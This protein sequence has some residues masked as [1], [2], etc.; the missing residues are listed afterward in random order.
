[1]AAF[2]SIIGLLVLIALKDLAP[3]DEPVAGPQAE[4][5]KLVAQASALDYAGQWDE[6]AALFEAV[7]R[8]PEY[9]EHHDYARNSIAR[10]CEKRRF[11]EGDA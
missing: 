2:L 7:L 8:E 3:D 11:A 6:A 4:G 9:H 5:E 1:M 10:I